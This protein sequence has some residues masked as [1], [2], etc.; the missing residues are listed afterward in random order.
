MAQQQVLESSPLKKHP[1]SE[2]QNYPDIFEGLLELKLQDS[3]EI[4]QQKKV[5]V[6][7]YI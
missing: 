7:I 5:K 1:S 3:T 6:C 4:P 2:A